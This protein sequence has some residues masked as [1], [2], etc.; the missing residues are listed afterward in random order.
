[1]PEAFGLPFRDPLSIAALIATSFLLVPLLAERLRLPGLVGLLL[2]GAAIGPNA[3]GLLER[4]ATM[5]LLGTVGL[6][7]LMFVIGLEIDIESFRRYRTR[8]LV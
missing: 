1:V 2:T 6:L 4:D 3:L 5:E 7:Y 8:S